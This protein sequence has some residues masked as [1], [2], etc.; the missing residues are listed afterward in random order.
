[1]TR[2]VLLVLVACTAQAAVLRSN[3]FLAAD[4]GEDLR[5][6]LVA[7]ALAKVQDE[8]KQQAAVFTECNSSS[9]Q[10]CEEAHVS[11]DHSCS[12]VV[13]AVVQGSGGDRN[14]AK[15]YMA[16]VCAQKQLQG[17][18]KLRCNDLA[19]AL[20]DHAMTADQY[21]NRN[22]FKPGKL[23]TS[24]WSQFVEEERK[25]EEQEAKERAEREK[26]EAEE[27]AK[28]EAE[29]KKKAEEEAKAEAKRRAEEAA[30]HEREEKELKAKKEAE[31]AQ[32]RAAEAEKLLAQKKAEAEAIQKAAQQKAE[33]A[34][35]AEQEHEARKAEHD[36]AEELLKSATK[37][38][39][40]AESEASAPVVEAKANSTEPVEKTLAPK[41]KVV[42]TT[43]P[44]AEPQTEKVVAKADVAPKAKAE[45]D[46]QTQKVEAKAE[47]KAEVKA[48]PLKVDTKATAPAKAVSK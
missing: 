8:W 9:G 13:S 28:A 45:V 43:A 20:V 12:T 42:E 18:R 36:K 48:A 16:T 39:S 30:R 14:V 10:N 11:F 34:A 15:E 7:Q 19:V 41:A 3:S 37:A 35:K 33:E 40:T 5:P 44:K 26:K 25:R 38:N 29:A 21:A 46:V 17:W 27:R 1:M 31:A 22:T 23:C 4:D 47:V 32:A 24:F 6:E 2:A